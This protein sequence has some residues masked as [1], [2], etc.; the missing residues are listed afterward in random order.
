LLISPQQFDFLLPF[1]CQWAEA[2]EARILRD[3]EQKAEAAV[4][5]GLN[6]KAT[7]NRAMSESTYLS[8]GERQVKGGV[9]RPLRVRAKNIAPKNV[10]GKSAK[11]VGSPRVYPV[12]QSN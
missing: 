8:K 5:Y 12:P 2:Q 10:T 11:P 1:A 6:G 4:G 7:A 9:D 3:S